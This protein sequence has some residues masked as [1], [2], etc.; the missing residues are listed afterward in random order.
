MID[1][2]TIEAYKAPTETKE[3]SEVKPKYSVLSLP[4]RHEERHCLW[5]D[6]DHSSK[7]PHTYITCPYF[8][9][10]SEQERVGKA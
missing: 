10:L 8:K 1:W 9:W 3:P 5:P 7:R 6:R 2:N 4:Y